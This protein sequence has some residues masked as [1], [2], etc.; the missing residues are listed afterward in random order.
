[1]WIRTQDKAEL[2]KTIDV[3]EDGKII[4]ANG[5]TALGEYAT[6]QR[7]FEVIDNLQSAIISGQI[8]FQMPKM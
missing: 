4:C 1:M 5:G 3:W 8:V 6:K 7:C 2:I